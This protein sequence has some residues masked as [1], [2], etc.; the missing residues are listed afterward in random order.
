MRP[1]AQIVR[2]RKSI[3]IMVGLGCVLFW[4]GRQSHVFQLA[5]G[6][7]VFNAPNELLWD[8]KLMTSARNLSAEVETTTGLKS[9]Q[10][11]PVVAEWKQ[12]KLWNRARKWL[13]LHVADDEVLVDPEQKD[14]ARRFYTQCGLKNL[15]VMNGNS[16]YV[17]IPKNGNNNIRCNLEGFPGEAEDLKCLHQ[18]EGLK[19]VGSGVKV[20][21]FVR[22]PISRFV[23][24]YTEVEF[25]NQ[26]TEKIQKRFKHAL[27]TKERFREYVVS[28]LEGRRVHAI[29]HTYSQSWIGTE[30]PVLNAGKIENMEEDWDSLQV[31]LG[32]RAPKPFDKAC[33][34]HPTS[35]DPLGTT[36]AA[37][38]ALHE[39]PALLNALCALLLPDFLNFHYE[40][41]TACLEAQD[42]SHLWSQDAAYEENGP[43][44][45]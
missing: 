15:A 5:G 34:T 39:D 32:V 45:L 37:H 12:A 9:Y 18:H 22:E 38:Q 8:N 35:R 40:L 31:W 42:F 28:M 41:P 13:E 1:D 3:W 36:A 2:S 7:D 33:S 44:V 17:R 10:I 6:K 25:R 24:G 26:N 4:I 20:W 21:T 11:H 23:S 30:F 27:G 14:V 29:F 16:V 19:L 43:L